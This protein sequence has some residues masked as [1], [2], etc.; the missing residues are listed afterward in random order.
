MDK[1][2]SQT[3]PDKS[4]TYAFRDSAK[5]AEQVRELRRKEK[6]LPSE[7]EMLRRLVQFALKNWGSRHPR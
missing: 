2:S 6:D 7:S 3:K 1:S 4:C 5:V